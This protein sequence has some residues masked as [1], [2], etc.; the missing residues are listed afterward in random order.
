MEGYRIVMMT[1]LNNMRNSFILVGTLVPN[2]SHL[3]IFIIISGSRRNI[4]T[5][6]TT[7]N[8]I[9]S[10]VPVVHACNPSYSRGRDQENYGSKPAWANSL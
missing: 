2:K 5:S 1:K 8:N 7:I 4:N 10:R 9:T 6:S 3:F